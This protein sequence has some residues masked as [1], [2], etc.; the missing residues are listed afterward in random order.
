M[1]VTRAESLSG[2][3][4]VISEKQVDSP[5]LLSL[6][7]AFQVALVVKKPLANAGDIRDSSLISGSA[8][9]PGGGHSNPLQYSCLENPMDRGAWWAT[10]H[11]VT[12]S[13]TQLKWLSMHTCTLSLWDED[14]ARR[15]R[16]GFHVEKTEGIFP[17]D[18]SFLCKAEGWLV[19]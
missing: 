1:N 7:W 14:G 19:C 17:P 4:D 10:V 12:K 13:R 5:Y 15:K 11:G 2:R 16:Y 8:R 18:Y 3:E 9:S 6:W